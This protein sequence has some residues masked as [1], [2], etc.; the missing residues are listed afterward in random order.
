MRR[1][2]C[3][4]SRRGRVAWTGLWLVMEVEVARSSI[5]EVPFL[6]FAIQALTRL[7]KELLGITVRARDGYR[8]SVGGRD[9]RL[10][11]CWWSQSGKATRRRAHHHARI[12][13]HAAL[14]AMRRACSSEMDPDRRSTFCPSDAESLVGDPGGVTFG[15][16]ATPP[17]EGEK[18]PN[19]GLAPKVGEPV[20]GAKVVVMSRR[21]GVL[22]DVPY[23][24]GE[25]PRRGDDRLGRGIGW[26]RA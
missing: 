11:S 12:V 4:P 1:T 16:G 13:R 23:E 10:T 18:P 9:A 6:C 17:D 2:W 22:G 3:A 8:Q 14:V 15:S 24:D 20:N 26:T 21:G 25:A 19:V 7:D 5:D